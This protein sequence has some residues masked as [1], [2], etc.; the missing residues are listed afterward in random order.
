LEAGR[1]HHLPASLLRHPPGFSIER[2]AQIGS[3]LG[4]FPTTIGLRFWYHEANAARKSAM[5]CFRRLGSLK[6]L[7][8]RSKIQF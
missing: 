6:I 3:I 5:P 2:G 7:M 8:S 1:G 4:V